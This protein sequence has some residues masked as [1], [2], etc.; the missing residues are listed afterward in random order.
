MTSTKMHKKP[1]QT[2]YESR[3]TVTKKQ[4]TAN[5]LQELRTQHNKNTLLQKTHLLPA[6]Q[7]ATGGSENYSGVLFRK[8]TA[9]RFL[10]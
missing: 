3:T 10:Q 1:V 6:L 4:S 9:G 8:L 2:H 5:T 7:E